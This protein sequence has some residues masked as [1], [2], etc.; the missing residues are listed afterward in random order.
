MWAC[1]SPLREQAR[2]EVV[3]GDRLDVD[4]V[5][6][7]QWREV[8]GGKGRIKDLDELEDFVRMLARD[9]TRFFLAIAPCA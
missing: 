3:S 8:A 7:P 1:G 5:V 6:D 9:E 2:D 4:Q